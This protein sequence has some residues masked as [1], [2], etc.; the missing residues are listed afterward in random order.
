MGRSMEPEGGGD[1]RLWTGEGRYRAQC[2]DAFADE[3]RWLDKDCARLAGSRIQSSP[4]VGLQMLRLPAHVPVAVAELCAS[5]V[6][7]VAVGKQKVEGSHTRREPPFG[8]VEASSSLTSTPLPKDAS[9]A[10]TRTS[11]FVSRLAPW[12]KGMV[13]KRG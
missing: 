7:W 8:Q 6:G 1:G 4:T 3:G 9:C 13:N 12:Q 5:L 10:L 11:P 2:K